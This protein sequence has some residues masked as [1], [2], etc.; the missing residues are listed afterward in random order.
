MRNATNLRGLTDAQR[1]GLRADFYR[2][3]AANP[4][5]LMRKTASNQQTLIQEMKRY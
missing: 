4:E 2:R 1:L 3:A 5:G